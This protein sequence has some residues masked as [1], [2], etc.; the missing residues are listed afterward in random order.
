VCGF[1]AG[2]EGSGRCSTAPG[3]NALAIAGGAAQV[4]C[5]LQISTAAQFLR[6]HGCAD[7]EAQRQNQNSMRGGRAR[8]LSRR[9]PNRAIRSF[10]VDSRHSRQA[11]FA[12]FAHGTEHQPESTFDS[13]RQPNA[14]RCVEA[15]HRGGTPALLWLSCGRR[16]GGRSCG[17]HRGRTAAK[18]GATGSGS[19][20]GSFGPTGPGSRAGGGSGGGL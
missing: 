6:R 12:R 3:N 4:F 2:S 16:R 20:S 18:G 15:S 5:S 8:H 10:V 11:V 19:I 14:S 13:D 7:A 1:V 17:R 9:D